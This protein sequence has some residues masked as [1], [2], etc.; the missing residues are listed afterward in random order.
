MEL[1]ISRYPPELQSQLDGM[2]LLFWWHERG[3]YLCTYVTGGYPYPIQDLVSE[4]K[5]AYLLFRETLQ[6]TTQVA[7][8]LE[9]E[10]PQPLVGFH[11]VDHRLGALANQLM[12]WRL[13]KHGYAP[14]GRVLSQPSLT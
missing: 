1:D 9:D 5:S 6:P 4:I 14:K 3:D 8:P 7:L 11:Q 10:P 2:H 13:G 12:E